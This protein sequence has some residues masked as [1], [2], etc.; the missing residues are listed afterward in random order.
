MNTIIQSLIKEVVHIEVSGKKSINGALVD[1]G[2][3][4][5]VLFNGLDFMYIPI[6]HIQM[7][8]PVS[9][10]ENDVQNPIIVPSN[11]WEE[12][13]IKLSYEGV[14]SQAKGKLMEIYITGDQ[15]LYGYITTIK[16]DYFEFYSP[17]YKSMYIA[18][19][20]VKW[21]IPIPQNESLYALEPSISTVLM[22]K[23]NLAETFKGQIANLINSL[24]VLNIE[25][26]SSQSGKI[27]KVEDNLLELQRARKVPI[28]LNID[29]IKTLHKV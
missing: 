24:V 22:E 5:I 2:E 28:N 27:G 15:P 7:I 8:R 25:G 29:H 13:N 20:H 9:S 17:I 23:N 6:Q 3:N 16:K 14:L 4:I 18:K 1:F 12:K 19:Q 10:D 11:M 26:N 21:L